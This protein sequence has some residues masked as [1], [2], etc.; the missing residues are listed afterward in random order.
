MNFY[1]ETDPVYVPIR[2]VDFTLK[3]AWIKRC[4]HTLT[5]AEQRFLDIV[6]DFLKV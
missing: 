1:S 5:E 3:T 4:R 6:I 2:D